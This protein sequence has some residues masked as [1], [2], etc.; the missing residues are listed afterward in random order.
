VRDYC[1]HGIGT[2]FHAAPQV[3][4]YDDGNIANIVNAGAN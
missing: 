4:H 1:G 3:M 2:T